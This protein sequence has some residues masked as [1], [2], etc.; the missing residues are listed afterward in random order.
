[1]QHLFLHTSHAGLEPSAACE[2]DAAL[3][4]GSRLAC[5]R[6]HVIYLT[7]ARP[8]GTTMISIRYHRIDIASSPT[9]MGRFS[10]FLALAGAGL[11]SAALSTTSSPD[12][13]SAASALAGNL[14]SYYSDAD[15]GVLPQPYWWWESAGMW[16]SMIHYSHYT[17][18]YTYDETVAAAIAAQAGPTQD[19]MGANTLGNDD[20]LWWGI[21]AMSAAEY[22]FRAP[23]SGSSWIQLAENVYH[24]VQGRWDTS[25]CNGGLHW[26]ISPSATGY[27]YK[28][29]ISNGLFFQLAARL[30]RYTGNSQY[31]DMANTIWDWS[32]TVG[33]VNP[34]SYNVYDGTDSTEGCTSL[35]HDQWSYNVGAYLYGAAVMLDVTG[36]SATWTPHVQGLV[37]AASAGFTNNG[38]LQESKCEPIDDCDTDQLSFKAYISRWLA[39]TGAMVPSLESQITPLLQASVDGALA[40]CNGGSDADVCG[41]KWTTDSYDGNIGVGQQLSALEIV[42]GQLAT[43]RP[44]PSKASQQRRMARS[45]EA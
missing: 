44:L 16:T 40:S 34:S 14:M 3:A 12:T 5:A 33:L 43:S 22:N 24:E 6:Q 21:A 1:M 29:A 9:T 2:D 7:S 36:D 19:F 41:M 23:A 13:C 45:F 30:A 27:S 37:S 18:D 8:P 4:Y 39:A 28:N 11:A 15:N 35:D 17:Q 10:S 31:T 25:T 38:V 26:Q 20:H 42:H 32:L